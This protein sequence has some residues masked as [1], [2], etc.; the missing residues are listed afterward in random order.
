MLQFKDSG[1]RTTT[2]EI[3]QICFRYT[4]IARVAPLW[5]TLGENYLIKNRDFLTTKGPQEGISYNVLMNG[6]TTYN[7]T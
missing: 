6:K 7:F 5:N 3:F 4:M 2:P 1:I